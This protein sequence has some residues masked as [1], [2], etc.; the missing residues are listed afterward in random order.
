MYTFVAQ[1]G[2][3]FLATDQTVK[4]M[5]PI[6]AFQRYVVNT[7]VSVENDKW[8]YYKH[9]F[10]QHPDDVKVFCNYALYILCIIY[11]ALYTHN[12][13]CTMH[14]AVNI[15]CFFRIFLILFLSYFRI[16][17]AFLSYTL[18]QEGKEAVAYCQIV[19][20]AVLKERTGKLCLYTQNHN[21]IT[22]TL[23]R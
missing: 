11:S 12:I 23:T 2:V 9:T 13:L 22:N 14:Y 15:L 18:I 1:K 4:Y 21:T 20:K 16:V 19:C 8:F 7:S 10:L 3:M 5:R 17:I 6:E